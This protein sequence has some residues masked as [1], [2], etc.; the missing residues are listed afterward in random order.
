MNEEFLASSDE[1]LAPATTL[2]EPKAPPD[3]DVM[4]PHNLGV[5]L[6]CAKVGIPIFPA[7]CEWND[8]KQKWDKF[9]LVSGN[10]KEIATTDE[11]QIR[12]WWFIYRSAVAG[13]HLEPTDLFVIDCDRHELDK[14]GVS[15]FAEMVANH[16]DLPPHPICSTAGGGEHHYFRQ[17]P[18]Q[19]LGNSLGNF[20]KEKGI[21]VRGNGGWVV[22]PG[23]YRVDGAQWQPAE[24]CQAFQKSSIPILPDWLFLKFTWQPPQ[25]TKPSK[26]ASSNQSASNNEQREYSHADL[27]LARE[28]LKD[29]PA[30]DRDTWRDIGFALHSTGLDEAREIW[31]EWSRK[32]PKFDDA[33]QGKTWQ[34]FKPEGNGKKITLGTLFHIAQKHGWKHPGTRR[35]PDD[36][37]NDLPA[38]DE[39]SLALAFAKRHEDELRYVAAWGHWMKYCD[40]HW[41]HDDTLYAFDLARIVCRE[42]AAEREKESAASTIASAKTVAAVDRLARAD[43]RLAA[44]SN[45][46]DINPHLLGTPSGT[47]DLQTGHMRPAQQFDYIT[48]IV[49]VSPGGDCPIW[50]KFLHRI[51]NGD[52]ELEQFIQRMLGYSLTGA[53]SEHAMF[54][55]HGTGANGKSVLIS[56]VAGILGDYHTTA[57][58]ET[59]V[60]SQMERHPTDI[61]ALRGARLVTAVETEEGRRWAETKIKTLTG[62]DR[63]SARFM[64]QDFF[65]FTPQFKLLIA[66]NNK[67][68]LRSVDEAIRRRL[69]LIP[70]AVTIP[71]KERDKALSEKLKAEWPGILSWMIDGC[72]EWQR[73]GLAPPLAVRDATENY[74]S[75]QDMFTQWLHE[76]CDAEPGNNHK[77]ETVNALFESFSN[78]IKRHGGE[79]GGKISF[80]DRLEA[81]GFPRDRTK[82]HGRIVRGIRL[83]YQ[84]G[85][86]R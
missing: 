35:Q 20:P 7:G 17:T 21:D 9:P 55:A 38:G 6:A 50:R 68:S 13:I 3:L 56:T 8:K 73:I 84:R 74:F 53:I 72:L 77:T 60:A 41:K 2:Q 1:C 47:L 22:A 14:D 32:S 65:E 82:Q 51:M 44:T 19:K 40:T 36:S 62:G 78:F 54:F 11:Q 64:R 45:Q 18:G 42:A 39:D 30:N 10:W 69:Y 4:H 29:V 80:G 66:G 76:M 52:A 28:A 37:E 85:D 16:K 31:D 48:K 67:P 25:E 70:F 26:S 49:T 57:P 27:K 33:D 81:K 59:F 86:D 61:A 79:P 75:D 15:F 63:L 46:W 12:K 34:S 24:L 43:R 71:E 58:I 83:K 5:A 23:S